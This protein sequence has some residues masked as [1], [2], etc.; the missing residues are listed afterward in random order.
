MLFLRRREFL[1]S[2]VAA[3]TAWVVTG[4]DRTSEPKPQVVA[5]ASLPSDDELCQR[6]DEAL[7]FT[8]EQ[9]LLNTDDHAAW[10][11]VHG[12]LAFQKA[13]KISHNGEKVGALD[14]LLDGGRLTGWT[15]RIGDELDPATGRRGVKAVIE[16]GSKTGQGHPDQWL[17][18]MSQCGIKPD[19][20][21]VVEG[22]ELTVQDWIEQI[23]WDIPN[24]PMNEYSWTVTALAMYLPTNYT[25]TASDGKTW[26][27]D[28]LM[29]IEA[30]QD[31]NSSACGGTHRLTGMAMALNQHIANGGKLEGG[32]KAADDKIQ[33]AIAKAKELQNPDGSFSSNYFA[34]PGKS[35][36]LA[37]EMG[38]TGHTAEFLTVALP[39]EKL[40]EPWV[41]AAIVR[42][43]DVF[44]KTEDLPMECGALYHGA[45]GL[46]LYRERIY[47]PRTFPREPAKSVAVNPSAQAS[48]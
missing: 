8:Y 17:G 29:Q 12:I 39:E 7:D 14:Y 1:C 10:Q 41:R 25:W 35:P 28:R 20:T 3:A 24:N 4:C 27:L 23:L 32:W 37:N 6:I 43:T 22:Q 31:I 40:R 30:E 16:P 36:D 19:R 42:L 46:L 47:G 15:M 33:W 48:K 13:Y 26:S 21:V 44:H 34:R 5:S 2:A 38:T 18:Y 9:R 11:V 45:H